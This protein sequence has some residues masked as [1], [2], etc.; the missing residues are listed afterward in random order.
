M[1][2]LKKNLSDESKW[3]LSALITSTNP[4]SK[5]KL[6]ELTNTLYIEK[7][8]SNDPTAKIISSRYVLDIHTARLEGAGL[9]EVTALGRIRVYSVSEFGRMLITHLS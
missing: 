8:I 7:G 3:I 5:E 6:W 9:V 1:D 2:I 4:T